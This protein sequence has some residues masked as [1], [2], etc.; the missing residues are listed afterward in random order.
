[1]EAVLNYL[2]ALELNWPELLKTGGILLLGCLLIGLF[3]RF[4]FGKK[5][6]V[7]CAVSSAFGIIFI[8]ALTVVLRSLELEARWTPPLPFVSFG[9]ESM[10][11][12]DFLSADYKE[13]CAQLL[14]MAVLAF[15]ISLLDT[16]LPRKENFFAWLFFRCLTVVLAYGLHIVVTWLLGRYL[17][18]VVVTYAPVILLALLVL[19][20]LTGAL[21][22]V[23]GALVATVNP[24][25]GAL[26]TF[27]FANIIGKQISK[28]L[29]TTALLAGLVLLLRYL[30]IAALCIAQSALVA[31]VPFLLIL[32]ALWYLLSRIL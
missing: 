18:G 28:A 5:S 11:F 9:A 2:T 8:C 6:A 19:M 23:V 1:M 26:Y 20:M 4:I 13:I 17:P 27:F 32:I 16:W 10:V 31:Y 3:G 29:F 14:S 22:I 15:L 30:G 21:K 25:I 7:S 12:F 24:I